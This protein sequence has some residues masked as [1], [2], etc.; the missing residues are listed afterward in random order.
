MKCGKPMHGVSKAKGCSHLRLGNFCKLFPNLKSWGADFGIKYQCEAEHVAK[1]LGSAG[2]IMHD[3]NS[4]SPDSKIPAAYTFFSQFIDHD[5]TL[6][7]AT[8]LHGE[9]LSDKVIDNLPN[10][11]SA[12]LDLDNIYGFGPDVMP[13][14]YD[15]TQL[16]RMLTGNSKNENDLPRNKD[17]RALIGDPRNDENIFV[18]QMQ[19]LFL[20]FHNRRIVGRSFEDAQKDCRYHYQWIV[21]YDFLKRICDSGVYQYALDELGKGKYPKCDI[22]DECGRICMPIEFSGAAYRFGHSLVRSQYPANT[23]YP[24]IDLFDERFG[25]EG[26]GHVPKKLT[27]DWRYLL[28]VKDC[29]PYVKSKAFDHLIADELIRMP[30][31]VVGR[32]ASD[33][34]RSLAF[35]NLLRG[36]VLGL[37]SGQRVAVELKAKGYKI[38]PAQDLKFDQLRGWSCLDKKLQEKLENHT[39]LFF[40][41]MREAG[42]VGKG[43]KLGPVGSAILMEVFGTM[44]VHC[45]SFLSEKGWKPDP[46]ISKKELTLADI[47]RY[48]EER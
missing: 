8:D 26:F 21:L 25:T 27:V 44:L 48:V 1:V 31:P 2:G 23:D 39:P 16:G 41:I 35:R 22:K 28:D 12:S 13:F 17:G 30:D 36:Y 45:D 42:V 46:C 5:I 14:L 10:M 43:D 40:Y 6:D 11:R 32:F 19:L 38:N 18:S 29:H 34:D 20:R 47:V 3:A 37:P 7:T 4:N 9:A 15:Q 33:D 24:V